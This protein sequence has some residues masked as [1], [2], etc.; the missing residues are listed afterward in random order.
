MI[1]GEQDIL[2]QYHFGQIDRSAAVKQLTDLYSDWYAANATVR[3][4]D[5]HPPTD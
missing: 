5:D 4:A 3:I 2:D 1:E